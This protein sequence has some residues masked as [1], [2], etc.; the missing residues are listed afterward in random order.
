MAKVSGGDKANKA[1]AKISEKLAK[2]ATLRVGFLE[3]ARYPNGTPVAWVAFLLDHG[4][5]R[6]PPRPFFRNMVA[7]KWRTWAPVLK[8]A[9]K[10]HN[11]DIVAALSVT[12]EVMVGQLKQSINETN[13]PPLAKST[14]KRKGFD[15]PLINTGHMLNSADYEVK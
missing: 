8:A 2:K 1:I 5:R 10:G 6:M 13:S 14:V 9:L 15:K 4:T 12:G 3:G 7:H 11:N